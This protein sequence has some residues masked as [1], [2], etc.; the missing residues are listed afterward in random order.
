MTHP[1]NR[2]DQSRREVQWDAE[3]RLGGSFAEGMIHDIS[4]GG[5]FFRPA[6]P[7]HHMSDRFD[8]GALS[9]LEPG[10]TVVLKY[11]PRIDSEPVTVLATVR[12]VG[13]SD[14]H[15]ASGVGLAFEDLE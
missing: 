14:E 7:H 12:W 6:G 11:T 1:S 3:C 13:K 8:D 9:F 15:Q 4:R 10:D 2:R 5:V